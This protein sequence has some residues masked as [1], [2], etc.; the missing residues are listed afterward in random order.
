MTHCWMGYIESLAFGSDEWVEVM[1]GA[2]PFGSPERQADPDAMPAD[3]TCMLRD[4]HKG[5]HVFT[6]DDEVGIYFV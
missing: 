2:G 4:G 3:G 5:A 6:P 1:S